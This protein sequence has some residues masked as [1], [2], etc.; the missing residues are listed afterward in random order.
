MKQHF[1]PMSSYSVVREQSLWRW[2]VCPGS[3]GFAAQTQVPLFPLDRRQP[4][5][6]PGWP[7]LALLHMPSSVIRISQKEVSLK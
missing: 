4:S 2:S 6:W 5:M 7:M 3:K 1:C